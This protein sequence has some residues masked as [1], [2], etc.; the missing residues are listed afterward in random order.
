[1]ILSHCYI[2]F[3]INKLYFRADF[4]LQQNW[5]ESTV[6]INT[7]YSP[8]FLNNLSKYQHSKSEFYIWQP[9][10]VSLPGEVHEHEQF[11]EKSMNSGNWRATVHRITKKARHNWGTDTF[12]YLQMYK[13][14]NLW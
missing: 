1:M 13:G 12:T 5:L 8:F 14:H 7:L 10:P 2:Y 6:S 11:M 3:K 4:N 9:T